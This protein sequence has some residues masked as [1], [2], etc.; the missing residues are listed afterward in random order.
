MVI[1]RICH[2]AGQY[3]WR[4]LLLNRR[5]EAIYRVVVVLVA[6]VHE[7]RDRRYNL[8][9]QLVFNGDIEAVVE[10]FLETCNT[11]SMQKL[12]WRPRVVSISDQVDNMSHAQASRPRHDS[13]LILPRA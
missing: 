4:I 9:R 3:R 5:I 13:A 6:E 12:T 8:S 7:I 10:G 1:E 11:T 2:R